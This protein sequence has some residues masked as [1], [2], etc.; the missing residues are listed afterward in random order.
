MTMTTAP[1]RPNHRAQATL[2]TYTP[3]PAPHRPH[4]RTR[5][6]LQTY[7]PF[8][9]PAPARSTP[10]RSAPLPRSQPFMS[11]R[12]PSPTSPRSR[13]FHRLHHP[14]PPI[15]HRSASHS[16]QE[17]CVPPLSTSPKTRTKIP[18]KNPRQCSATPHPTRAPRGMGALRALGDTVLH[19]AATPD[20]TRAPR[21]LGA[22]RAL[23]EMV[24]HAA[25]IGARIVAQ[26]TPGSTIH[27]TSSRH[28]AGLP[29]PTPQT[30][31]PEV[32]EA[33]AALA[34][35]SGPRVSCMIA[36]HRIHRSRCLMAI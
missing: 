16:T 26:P 6:T 8:P 14:S 30:A 4:H 2:R 11:L 15:R 21:D 35:S 9:A 33:P 24:L 27:P 31:T 12:L 25:A 32:S 18:R 10:I 19:A 17:V 3:F 20:P 7:P 13:S 29:E 22:L 23:G 5:P 28:P 34:R 1:H 36:L